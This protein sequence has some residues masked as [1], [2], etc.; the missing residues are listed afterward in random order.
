MAPILVC[1]TVAS[2]AGWYGPATT[3]SEH[4]GRPVIS[5]DGKSHVPHWFVGSSG[6]GRSC[7]KGGS[8]LSAL[9][10]Q[11][12]AAAAAG[13]ELVEVCLAQWQL[14]A[15]YP[16]GIEPQTQHVIN[17][18]LHASLHAK[19]V[20]RILVE[21]VTEPITLQSWRNGSRLNVTGSP[22]DK[23]S[24]G[25][26][27]IAGAWAAGAAAGLVPFVTALDAAYP[28]RVAGVHLTA[29]HSGEWNWPGMCTWD[30]G[31]NDYAADY[32]EPTRVDFCL[33]SHDLSDDSTQESCTLP[34][35]SERNKPRT[36]N[37][38]V[39]GPSPSKEASL[40]VEANRLLSRLTARAIAAL[41]DALKNAS[42]QRLL[43]L[44]FHG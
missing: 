17:T 8:N 22:G 1:S 9:Y 2:L 15:S 24:Q 29:M 27:T 19:L 33:D 42:A 26:S 44:A 23:L 37:S 38:F 40:V 32:S 30:T 6:L 14:N 25:V 5:V 36:G 3:V 39:C 34:T 21:H 16:G 4:N 35:A 20:L 31:G 18:V 41:A 10:V 43:V 13:F 11:V 7:A 28:K 12:G